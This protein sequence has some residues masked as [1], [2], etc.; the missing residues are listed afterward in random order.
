MVILASAKGLA[1]RRAAALGWVLQRRKKARRE[2]KWNRMY[3]RPPVFRASLRAACAFL[4]A[5]HR[6]WHDHEPAIDST[7]LGRRMSW[8]VKMANW[9]HNVWRATSIIEPLTRGAGG[10][11]RRCSSCQKPQ[12]TV[13]PRRPKVSPKSLMF[14]DR[15]G[16]S[17]PVW[18]AWARK[19]GDGRRWN[20]GLGRGGPGSWKRLFVRPD[21]P[22]PPRAQRSAFW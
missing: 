19:M 1:R 13:P 22:P 20:K 6:S 11:Q 3:E 21:Q 9:S 7:P 10:R 15:D 18:R 14:L 5:T 4:E 16:I 8:A 2:A 12:T 17:Y